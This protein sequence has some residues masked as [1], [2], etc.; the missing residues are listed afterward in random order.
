MGA[1]E[2]EKSGNKNYKKVFLMDFSLFNI[3]LILQLRGDF[4]KALS[5]S[6]FAAQQFLLLRITVPGYE[7]FKEP[8]CKIKRKNRS[9]NENKAHIS[10]IP[11]KQ[12]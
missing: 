12:L 4:S 2:E 9:K 3:L 11:R 7:C 1:N 10:I 6:S 5:T 8:E